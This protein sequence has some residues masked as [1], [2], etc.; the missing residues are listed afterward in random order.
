M[1]WEYVTI[2]N[3]GNPD[4]TARNERDWLTNPSNNRVASYHIVVDAKEAIEC[5]PFDE[6][7]WHAGDGGS[8]T[9]NRTSVGVEIC[10]SGNYDGNVRHAVE[11]VADLLNSKNKDTSVLRQHY[12]WSGKNCPRLIRA[13]VAGWSWSAFIDAVKERLK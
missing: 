3:T 2:H 1:D 7:A 4:S 5:I 6:V 11:V 12:D 8:G 13:G 9:G 10:E